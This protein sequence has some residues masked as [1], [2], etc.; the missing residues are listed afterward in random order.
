MTG[1]KKVR[2]SSAAVAAVV[3]ALGIGQVISG[4]AVRADY[5]WGGSTYPCWSSCPTTKPTYTTT[6]TKPTYTTM[7]TEPTSTTAEPVPKGNNGWGN[8]LDGDNPG[9]DK[10]RGVSQGNGNGRSLPGPQGAVPKTSTSVSG[11]AVLARRCALGRAPQAS[12]AA[13]ENGQLQVSLTSSAGL[14]SESML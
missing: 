3:L 2:L 12:G 10:G 13:G 5:G 4:A 8:G 11:E 1:N 14:G 6:T 7:K 9:T